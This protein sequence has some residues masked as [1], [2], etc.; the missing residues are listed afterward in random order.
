MDEG[1]NVDRITFRHLLTHRSGFVTG[2]SDSDFLFMK[3]NVAAG[4]A[5][6]GSSVAYENMNFGLCRI[7]LAT[8]AGA[9]ATNAS[10]AL[11]GF[12][13]NDVFWDFLTIDAYVRYVQE[14]VFAPAGVSGPTL[15]HPAAH[16]LGYD[17]PI[18]AHGWNSGDLRSV[19]GG[20]AWHMSVDDL[21]AVMSAVRRGGT[22]MTAARAQAMLDDR[23]GIDEQ[24]ETPLGSLYW[25]GGYWGDTMGRREQSLVYFLPR[26]ME[27]ALLTNSPVDSPERSFPEVVY[28]AYITNIRPATSLRGFLLRHHHPVTSS[29]HPLTGPARS[30]REMLPN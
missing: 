19:A 4:V 21:V 30:L 24:Q 17:F 9:V 1:P 23:F 28:N 3:A 2:K 26:E 6:V 11:P 8:I 27:L 13:V 7:L 10:F 15:D 20:V 16:A 12:D 29:V 22:I 5:A 25:K 18:A 14:S